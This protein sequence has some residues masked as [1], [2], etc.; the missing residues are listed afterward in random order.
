MLT[1]LQ[2]K[3][4]ERGTEPINTL[5]LDFGSI[6]KCRLTQIT[7]MARFEKPINATATIDP[8]HSL[9]ASRSTSERSPRTYAVTLKFH[10]PQYDFPSRCCIKFA[11]NRKEY[12]ALEWENEV[13]T[14]DLQ[15]LQGDAVPRLYGFF[16]AD[17]GNGKVGCLVMELCTRIDAAILRHSER[18]RELH[19][20]VMV[21][22]CKVHDANIWHGDLRYAH[23]VMNE[24]KVYIVDFAQASRHRCLGASAPAVHDRDPQSVRGCGELYDAESFFGKRSGGEREDAALTKAGA[25]LVSAF[26]FGALG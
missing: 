20:R 10:G 18:S 15:R 14:L 5:E 12:D 3:P 6:R 11:S 4:D 19:R 26:T 16:G 8:I 17:I 24:G 23:C 2:R 13:Y 9:I 7:N 21:A 1:D 25:W 22:I